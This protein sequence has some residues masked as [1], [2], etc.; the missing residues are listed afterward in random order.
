M[1]HVVRDSSIRIVYVSEIDKGIYDAM[2][3]GI[4]RAEGDYILFLNAGDI[5]SN[6]KVVEKLNG[7]I[8]GDTAE[9]IYYGNYYR[10]FRDRSLVLNRAKNI[11]YIKHGLPTSHQAILYPSC[12]LKHIKYSLS[13][14]V[15]SDYYMTAKA[16]AIGIGFKKVDINISCF[17]VGGFSQNNAIVAIMETARIQREVL[18][19]PVLY[20][21][22]S[23]L[24]RIIN[25]SGVKIIKH[26]KQVAIFG[27]KQNQGKKHS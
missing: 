9:I 8:K 16:K 12:L 17:D 21:L 7:I 14:K 22:L 23:G 25:M 19:L 13:Y 5:L 27:L 15:C 3:K 18:K 26:V 2:N 4:N 20:I 6:E 11:E 24:R 10:A 1:N